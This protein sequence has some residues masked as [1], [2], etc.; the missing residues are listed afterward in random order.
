VWQSAFPPAP[1]ADPSPSRARA[2]RRPPKHEFRAL[3]EKTATSYGQYWGLFVIFAMRLRRLQ[4]E[5]DH[6]YAVTMTASQERCLDRAWKY[7]ERAVD[8]PTGRRMLLDVSR[9]FW[10]PDS[11]DDFAHMASD[12]FDDPTVRF[13]VLTNLR[14]D[15]TFQ[16]PRDA[17]SMLVKIK[18]FIRA[19]LYM[20]SRYRQKHKELPVHR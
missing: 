13:G 1:G 4:L 12:Q 15:G 19:A 18:Y 16:A 2:L 10:C 11:M 20:W 5:G 6:R 9:W 17:S 8:R 7:A 14:T 3:E